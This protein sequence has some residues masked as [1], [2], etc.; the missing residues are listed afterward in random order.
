MFERL[1]ELS[2][3]FIGLWTSLQLSYWFIGVSIEGVFAVV[4]SFL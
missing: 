2:L 1:S 3:G 4:G